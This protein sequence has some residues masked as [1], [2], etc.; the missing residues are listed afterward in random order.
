MSLA[1]EL[2]DV[3]LFKG[4]E[5]RTQNRSI[6]SIREGSIH[7]QMDEPRDN[8]F[9]CLAMTCSCVTRRSSAVPEYVAVA[10]GSCSRSRL[11]G[12]NL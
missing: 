9:P 6:K 12:G 5:A 10:E 7:G 2:G 4:K 11:C 3:H 1:L 8:Y